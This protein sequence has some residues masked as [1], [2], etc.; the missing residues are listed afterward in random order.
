[1][2]SG[3]RRCAA[4][5]FGVAGA[6]VEGRCAT[7]NLPWV[8][9]ETTLART[10]GVR[11][12]DCSTIS[13]RPAYG[14]LHLRADEFALLQAGTAPA[15]KGNAAVISPAPALVRRGS[16]GMGPL[17]P[18]RLGRWHGDFAPEQREGSR[19][20]ALPAE[21]VRRTHQLRARAVGTRPAEHLLFSPRHRVCRRVT[22]FRQ[23]DRS[24]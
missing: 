5:C 11:V 18:G 17:P 24:R 9:E 22:R 21:Q 4:V 14:M 6:I 20:V 13:K 1:V 7:T 8:M 10:L 15:R 16:T 3:Q 23:E 2:T 19:I 12:A